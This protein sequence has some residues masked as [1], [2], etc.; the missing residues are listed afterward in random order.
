MPLLCSCRSA[1]DRWLSRRRS[2][3][4]PHAALFIP[5]GKRDANIIA[6]GEYGH[7]LHDDLL[8]RARQ[9]SSTVE[10]Q[11]DFLPLSNSGASIGPSHVR[12]PRCQQESS[13]IHTHTY[14][15]V[16]TFI[17]IYSTIYIY[18]YIYIYIRVQHL[19]I[20]QIW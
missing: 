5:L 17:Y 7:E 2:P 1:V 11:R 10:I 4:R 20:R 16:C 12:A 13:N 6:H 15:S 19:Y 18:I 8:Q 9:R 14:I 3:V